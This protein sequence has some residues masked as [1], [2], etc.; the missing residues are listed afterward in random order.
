MNNENHQ[1]DT[2]ALE[3]NPLGDMTSDE[4][5]E[6]VAKIRA[7]DTS[8]LSP[9]EKEHLSKVNRMMSHIHHAW[10]PF[11]QDEHGTMGDI[12]LLPLS[13]GVGKVDIERIS[14]LK[15]EF[16]NLRAILV[17]SNQLKP[18][19]TSL[20]YQLI[21]ALLGYVV[22]MRSTSGGWR[23]DH[24]NSVDHEKEHED[25][26]SPLTSLQLL[27]QS[28]PL[29]NR[30]FRPLSVSQTVSDWM[31]Y[32]SQSLPT[33]T[34]HPDGPGRR[35]QAIKALLFDVCQIFTH[36]ELLFYCLFD[37]WLL[38]YIS[39]LILNDSSLHSSTIRQLS[40]LACYPP[41]SHVPLTET[42]LPHFRDNSFVPSRSRGDAA[43]HSIFLYTKKLSFLFSDFLIRSYDPHESVD[44]WRQNLVLE[45]QTYINEYL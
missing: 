2:L 45:L 43:Q 44:S 21:G 1:G 22:M 42:I 26:D 28:T 14:H 6:L 38:G 33:P 39:S 37:M 23:G 16:T 5:E 7:S 30:S 13:S 4:L 36:R 41:P 19:Q 10:I 9:L 25:M 17:T 20:C 12:C 34:R 32:S 27:L 8:S 35:S 18:H 29:I 31:T 3:E 11:W 24:V 40:S 15:V